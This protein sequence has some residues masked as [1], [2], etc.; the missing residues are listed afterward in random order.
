MGRSHR[1]HIFLTERQHAF[2]EAESERSSVSIG[3]L[4][5]RAIDT[6]YAP[7]GP[8]RVQLISHVLGRRTG[9]GLR[10]WRDYS[11]PSK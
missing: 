6:A 8:G 11:S 5:R 10:D 9:V 3:E 7:D 1:F 2:L 4:I